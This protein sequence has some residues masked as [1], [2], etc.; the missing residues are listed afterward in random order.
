MNNKPLSPSPANQPASGV[1]PALIVGLVFAGLVLGWLAGFTLEVAFG[2]IL[3]NLDG[4][5][6]LGYALAGLRFTAPV[7]GPSA[8][9]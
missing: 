2:F 6:F 1:N 9:R 5:S 4:P 3:H 7:L 8:C